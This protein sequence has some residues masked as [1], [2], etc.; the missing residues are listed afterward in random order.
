MPGELSGGER[1]RAAIA[2]ALVRD[3]PLLLLDE[4][5]A[6]LGPALKADMLELVGSI[7][8]ERGMTILMVTH[9]PDDAKRAASHTAF[10][11]AGTIIALEPTQALFARQDIP[12]LSAYLGR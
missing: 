2:R 11:E 8:R 7:H 4:P 3:K 12:E 6:A 9:H 5:F 10:L 1:Q